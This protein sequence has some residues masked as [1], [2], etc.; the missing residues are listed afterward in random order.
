MY[1]RQKKMSL[2]LGN[3]NGEEWYRLRSNSQQKL[4]RPREVQHHL[5]SVNQIAREFTDRLARIRYINNEVNDLKTE[6]RQERGKF[7]ALGCIFE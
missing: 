5:P 6:V 7:A 4:L 3:T 2:G 1:R